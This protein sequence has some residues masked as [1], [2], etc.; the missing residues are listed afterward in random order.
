M[1]P[2]KLSRFAISLEY[3]DICI[4]NELE[5]LLPS[6]KKIEKNG[7]SNRKSKATYP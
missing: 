2:F 1:T 3:S 4:D 7:Y 6:V 5:S